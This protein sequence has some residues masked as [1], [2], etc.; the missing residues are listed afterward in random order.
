MEIAIR[1]PLI[2][3]LPLSQHCACNVWLK[4][5]SSQPTGSFKLRSAEHICRHYAEKGAKAFISS[6]GGNAGH[7]V[8]ANWGCR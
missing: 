2:H 7:T 3:S 6:S 5:E 8:A 4:M 1:T